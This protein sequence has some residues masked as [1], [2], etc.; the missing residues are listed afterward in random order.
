ML[1]AVATVPLSVRSV[2]VPSA[3]V[4]VTPLLTLIVPPLSTVNW[5]ASTLAVTVTVCG[6][7]TVMVL[8]ADVGVEVAGV[9]VVPSNDSSHVEFAF[10]LPDAA[11]R[12]KGAKVGV[13]VIS[14]KAISS[15]EPA[16]AT[17]LLLHLM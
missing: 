10:Q 11:L 13:T 3:M 2:P 7:R 4:K 5:S 1:A 16:P 6:L 9:K 17:S 14:S 8:L 15:L 12:K